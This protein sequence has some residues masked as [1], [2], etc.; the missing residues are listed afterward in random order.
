M[1]QYLE[2]CCLV[3]VCVAII[4]LIYMFFA[5]RKIHIVYKKIDYL[6]EDLTYKIELLTPVVDSIV[7][8]SNL[9]DILNSVLHEKSKTIMKYVSGNQETIHKVAQEIKSIVSKKK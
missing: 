7:K 5:F 8:V 2:I 1:P 9:I 4:V 3:L 6:V